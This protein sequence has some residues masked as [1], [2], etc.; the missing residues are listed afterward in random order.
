M[1]NLLTLPRVNVDGLSQVQDDA[2]G[3]PIQKS[4]G[5]GEYLLIQDKVPTGGCARD[6]GTGALRRASGKIIATH[7]G[8]FDV[9]VELQS[10]LF[11]RGS[12]SHIGNDYRAI[13]LDDLDD[14]PGR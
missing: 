4:V 7:G 5:R 13:A 9:G 14:R 1:Q 11:D 3:K 6:Q 2:I 10:H 8:S 12:I